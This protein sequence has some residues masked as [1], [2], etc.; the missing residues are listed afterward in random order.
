MVDEVVHVLV[1]DE[2]V[3]VVVVELVVHCARAAGAGAGAPFVGA[4]YE[5]QF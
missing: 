4:G 3:D 5:N 2:E 1:V